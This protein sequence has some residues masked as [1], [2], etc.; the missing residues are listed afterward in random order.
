MH[1]ISDLRAATAVLGWDQETY[2]PDGAVDARAEQIATLSTL[3]HGFNTN[4]EA[5]RIVEDAQV[6]KSELPALQQRIIGRFIEDQ[7]RSQKL[8]PQFIDE[9]ARVTSKGQDAWKK[10]RASSDFSI[11]QPH[12]ESIV[13][14]KQQEAELTSVGGN[15]YNAL[16]DEY[17]PGLTVESLTPIFQQ[18]KD[19]TTAILKS[20]DANKSMVSDEILYRHY[21][22]DSQMKVAKQIIQTLGFDSN[23]GRIDLST[24]PFCTSFSN[25]DVRLT[26]RVR[27]NDLRSCLFGLIHEAGHGMY[28]QGVAAELDRTSG[29]GGASMGIHESQSLF[30]ENTIA[31]S[32][33]FWEWAFPIV[34]NQF[35]SQLADVTPRDFYK[36][37]NKITPSLNRVES[38][39]LTYNLHIILRYEIENDLINGR[40]AVAD[41]PAAWNDKMSQSLGVVPPN[42][43][44]GCLQDV[45]WSFGGIGYF[46]SY[47]LGK[48]FAAMQWNTMQVAIPN[49]KALVA[50][51]DFAPVLNWLRT[52]VHGVGRTETPTEISVRVCG[53]PLAAYDFLQYIG[54]KAEDVYG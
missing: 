35:P 43:A 24:H 16:L 20:I 53:K 18:L 7:K 10:S 39:E 47:S 6:Y 54:K 12:L 15:L 17:E 1:K 14:L 21:D 3:I 34:K 50:N 23:T 30:W 32:E 29:A 41:I 13:R 40:L 49:V 25:T 44:E 36:A 9:L 11:F 48:L 31:R 26:T 38:D 27:E 33:E 46:P 45:H 37:I 2:M 28:E 52:N 22:G 42:D 4:D 19:G 5:N 8:S 51:G